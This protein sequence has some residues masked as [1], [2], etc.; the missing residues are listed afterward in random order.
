MACI[1]L[2]VVKPVVETERRTGFSVLVVSD[3]VWTQLCAANGHAP[4]EEEAGA[5]RVERIHLGPDFQG[6]C[7]EAAERVLC[8]VGNEATP[9]AFGFVVAGVGAEFHGP[10]GGPAF[11]ERD[12]VVVVSRTAG[13]AHA[14]NTRNRCLQEK[15]LSMQ[16]E[17]VCYVY[18]YRL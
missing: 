11:R 8:I 7:V 6:D 9:Y 4:C 2:C 18:I 13:T 1:G 16:P 14:Q 5:G 12:A 10:T 3:V 15:S 17:A